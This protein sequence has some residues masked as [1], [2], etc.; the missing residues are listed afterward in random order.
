MNRVELL[1]FANSRICSQIRLLE[2][3]RWE[4]WGL[5]KVEWACLLELV[6]VWNFPS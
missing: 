6:I 3:P 4:L 2:I 5:S 1:C